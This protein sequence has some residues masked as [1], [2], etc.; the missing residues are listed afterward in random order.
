MDLGYRS[1]CF[2]ASPVWNHASYKHYSGYYSIGFLA[3][4]RVCQ[5]AEKARQ[6]IKPVLLFYADQL[7]CAGDD[8]CAIGGSIVELKRWPTGNN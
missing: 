3:D 2:N 1:F 7:L 4:Y 5:F 8:C 6:T